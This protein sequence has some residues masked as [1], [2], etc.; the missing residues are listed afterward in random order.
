M[1]TSNGKASHMGDNNVEAPKSSLSREVQV[2]TN[3]NSTFVQQEE[4]TVECKQQFE[5]S[6][7]CVVDLVQHVEESDMFLH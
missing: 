3:V 5:I 1:T 7:L 4:H 2:P 6:E